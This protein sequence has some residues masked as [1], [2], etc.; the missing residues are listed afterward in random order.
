MK[1]NTIIKTALVVLLAL[2]ITAAGEVH[3]F[4]M[5]SGMN[6]PWTVHP[7]QGYSHYGWDLGR[8]PWYYSGHEGYSSSLSSLEDDFAYLATN[9]VKLCRIFLFCDF[10]TGLELDDDGYVTGF[11]PWVYLDMDE[12]VSCSARHQL[13]LIPVLMDFMMLDGLSLGSSGGE[14]PEFITNAIAQAAFMKNILKPFISRYGTNEN[15]YAWEIMNE[16]GEAT[17][18]PKPDLAQFIDLCASNI[19]AECPSALTTCGIYNTDELDIWMTPH[20]NFMQLHQ[21]PGSSWDFNTPATSWSDNPVLIGET[22]ITSDYTQ[23]LE[24]AR[25]TGYLGVLA[26]SL[27]D[28]YYNYDIVASG[29]MS[30]MTNLFYNINSPLTL[31][32]ELTQ[33]EVH[34]QLSPTFEG[35]TYTLHQTTNLTALSWATSTFPAAIVTNKTE[36]MLPLNKG[37]RFYNV[38]TDF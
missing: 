4:P 5:R 1:T 13:K 17:S 31:D 28:P 30:Y 37:S 26:W 24:I 21:Y 18:V 32:I 33:N 38:S 34:L 22:P 36:R 27:N 29:Y 15:I 3:N 19:L 6:L 11:D 12:L 2:I 35:N 8:H 16:P 7:T 14:H 20:L 25:S 10:R 23:Q 9:K